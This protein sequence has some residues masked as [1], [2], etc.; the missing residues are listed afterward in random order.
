MNGVSPVEG[1]G[2]CAGFALAITRQGGAGTRDYFDL[3]GQL[4]SVLV[5]D[6]AVDEDMPAGNKLQRVATMNPK[7]NPVPTLLANWPMEVDEQ[8]GLWM[9][10]LHPSCSRKK[11]RAS[12][13]KC[14]RKYRWRFARLLSHVTT[15]HRARPPGTQGQL[16]PP[17]A[18]RLSYGL[19]SNGWRVSLLPFSCETTA[20]CHV[21]DALACVGILHN[22][23][24]RAEW[25]SGCKCEGW[26][27]LCKDN[28]IATLSYIV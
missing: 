25:E 13:Q 18:V 7:W 2:S 4:A 15:V 17:S 22:L 16:A 21:K 26:S 11:G 10:C 6:Q 14:S 5:Q 1:Q 28:I 8:H 3:E 20:S 23:S 24:W 19:H 9:K 12:T 27:G